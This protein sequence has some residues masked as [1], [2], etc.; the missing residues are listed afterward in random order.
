MRTILRKLFGASTG[1]GACRCDMRYAMRTILRKLFGASTGGGAC[2]SFFVFAL[3]GLISGIPLAARAQD[4]VTVGTV[5]FRDKTAN[6]IV[7]DGVLSFVDIT[8]ANAS[9]GNED[10]RTNKFQHESTMG[11]IDEFFSPRQPIG[12]GGSWTATFTA[13]ETVTFDSIRFAD[14]CFFNANWGGVQ[15]SALTARLAVTV[16]DVSANAT[17]SWPQGNAQ[18]R[19]TEATLP[20]GQEVTLEQGD[21]LT[22]VAANGTIN[23]CGIGFKKMEFLGPAP[24]TQTVEWVAGPNPG[25]ASQRAAIE[26]FGL[27]LDGLRQLGETVPATVPETAALSS[28]MVEF[29]GN[30]SGST[31]QNVRHLVLTDEA[32]AVVAVSAEAS[33]VPTAEAAE[34]TFAFPSLPTLTLSV[35]YKG[36]FVTAEDVPEVGADFNTENGIK[37]RVALRAD[38]AATA[39][40]NTAGDLTQYCVAAQFTLQTEVSADE[41]E[42]VW[43]MGPPNMGAPNQGKYKEAGICLSA[44]AGVS[45]YAPTTLP[46]SVDLQ[47]LTARWD[48]GQNDGA[49]TQV[50]QAVITDAEHT[51]VAASDV[52]SAPP[53]QNDALT[54]FSFSSPVTLD[55]A[56]QYLVYFVNEANADVAVGETFAHETEALEVRLTIYNDAE[57]AGKGFYVTDSPSYVPAFFIELASSSVPE[58]PLGALNI[59]FDTNADRLADDTLYGIEGAQYLGS[60]WNDITTCAEAYGENAPFEAQDTVGNTVTVT[61]AARLLGNNNVSNADPL[62]RQVLTDG[63]P[64]VNPWIELDGIPYETYDVYIYMSQHDGGYLNGSVTL[65]EDSIIIW[66]RARRSPLRPRR[67]PLGVQTTTRNRTWFWARMLSAF[68]TSPA[69]RCVS[70]ATAEVAIVPTSLRFRLWRCGRSRSRRVGKVPSKRMPLLRR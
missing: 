35:P 14:T 47:A 25:A 37:T 52:L 64:T 6:S 28:V 69:Q 26:V 41:I 62:L 50:R 32:G 68:R 2:L 34:I 44:A 38:T 46:T 66:K 17:I 70:G 63:A 54:V 10:G 45:E 60:Q 5:T 19:Y 48:W 11:L 53:A 39:A 3:T 65:N 18:E 21:T 55:V 23:H 16:G 42:T 59:N 57:T 27:R 9:A 1:G 29:L 12:S 4:S 49:V 30:Q 24:A 8:Q 67:T 51:V 43:V 31:N 61:Y 15:S 56:A 20:M 36:Y 22:L 33:P 40:G 58:Q 7:A 13:T